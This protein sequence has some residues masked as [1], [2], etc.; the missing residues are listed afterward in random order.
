MSWPGRPPRREGGHLNVL[1]HATALLRSTQ[2]RRAEVLE[3]CRAAVD[4]H[5]QGVRVRLLPE[6]VDAAVRA[7]RRDLPWTGVLRREPRPGWCA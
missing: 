3:V 5:E 4:L 6:F 1:E 2:G 7:G